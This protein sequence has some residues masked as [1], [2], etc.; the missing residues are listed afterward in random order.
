MIWI[1]NVCE[2]TGDD[3]NVDAAG[4]IASSVKSWRSSARWIDPMTSSNDFESAE[5]IKREK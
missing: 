3:D 2:E 4:D 1:D 5:L